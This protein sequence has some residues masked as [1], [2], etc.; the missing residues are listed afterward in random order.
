MKTKKL[1]MMRTFSVLFC[2]VWSINMMAQDSISFF[3]CAQI[4][5]DSEA[6]KAIKKANK[7]STKKWNAAILEYHPLVDGNIHYSYILEAADTFNI[8]QM[9]NNTRAWFGKI[10]SSELTAVKNVDEEKFIIEAATGESNVGQASG[11]GSASVVGVIMNYRISF[12]KNR[13]KFDVWVSHYN[14]T[15]V[16]SLAKDRTEVVPITEAYPINPKGDHKSSLG[17]AFINVNV[18]C[19]TAAML[20]LDFMEKNHGDDLKKNKEGDW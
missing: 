19:S 11:Y 1:S 15:T 9:M 17:T 12:K 18:Y 8:K 7:R 5:K 2:M 20:Y 14:I 4:Q 13:I 3:S 16:G 10:S 6:F